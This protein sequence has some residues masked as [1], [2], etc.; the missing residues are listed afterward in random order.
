MPKIKILKEVESKIKI[1]GPIRP[2][3][4]LEQELDEPEDFTSGGNFS[5][6]EIMERSGSPTLEMSGER[7]ENIEI[8][9][10]RVQLQEPEQIVRGQTYQAAVRG[11]EQEER[12]YRATTLR[13]SGSETSMASGIRRTIAQDIQSDIHLRHEGAAFTGAAGDESLAKQYESTER[14]E[15]GR[16]KRRATWDT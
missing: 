16:V 15:G 1:I 4:E 11:L 9:V 13:S 8:P 12:E 10:E 2:E 3:S 6:I 14:D 5:D 7:Q